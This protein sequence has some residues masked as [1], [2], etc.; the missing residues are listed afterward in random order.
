[1]KGPGG[2]WSRWL[3]GWA[4]RLR[5]PQLFRLTLA[6]F[7]L[8]LVVPDLI[9]FADEILLGLLTLLLGTLRK[10]PGP[11]GAPGPRRTLDARAIPE[12]HPTDPKR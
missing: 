6:L 4:S 7:I 11:A 8:D 10:E 9:P 12:R 5:F 3:V 2:F 1:M